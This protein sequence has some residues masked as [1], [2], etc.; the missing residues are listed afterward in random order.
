MPLLL[1]LLLFFLFLFF[2]FGALD[3]DTIP[4]LASYPNHSIHRDT[5]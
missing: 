5:C 2:V 4:L 3:H 1:L